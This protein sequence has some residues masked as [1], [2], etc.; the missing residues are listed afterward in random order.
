MKALIFSA[1]FGTRLAPITNKIPK[2]LIKVNGEIML[3]RIIKNLLEADFDE[4]FINTHYLADKIENFIKKQHYYEKIKIFYEDKILETGGTLSALAP[5]LKGHSPVLIHNCD[6]YIDIDIKNFYLSH[7]TQNC[8][9]IAV[10]NIPTTRPYLVDKDKY[11]VGHLNKKT[12]KLTLKPDTKKENLEEY[13]NCGIYTV[14]QSF[15]EYVKTKDYTG[16]SITQAI[17]DGIIYENMKIK[18]YDIKNSIYSDVGTMGKIKNLEN[19]LQ[20][21]HFQD[22]IN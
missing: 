10:K 8:V 21:K 12:N 5:Q 20:K 1:G 18:A 7:K 22:T 19:I 3:D 13:I 16:K 11:I 17:L 2:A 15:L 9:S 6:T 14:S 4:I